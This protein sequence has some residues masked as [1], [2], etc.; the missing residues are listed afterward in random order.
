MAA[1][2]NKTYRYSHEEKM[3]IVDKYYDVGGSTYSL[4]HKYN[5]PR[6]SIKN[7]IEKVFQ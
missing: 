4:A 7:Q 1:K 2:V 5:I 3:K 6:T